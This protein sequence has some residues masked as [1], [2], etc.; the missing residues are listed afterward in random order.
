[1]NN[2]MSERGQSKV[3]YVLIIVLL[4]VI[5]LSCIF[6]IGPNLVK[7]YRAAVD[8]SSRNNHSPRLSAAS[9]IT[10]DFLDGIQDDFDKNGR[11]LRSRGDGRFTDLV[12][13]LADWNEPVEGI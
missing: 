6:T 4:A 7:L 3:E 12:L 11:W 5:V 13:T 9:K 8:H 10:H 2:N 1:M